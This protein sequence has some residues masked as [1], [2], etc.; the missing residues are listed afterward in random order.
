MTKM[1]PLRWLDAGVRGDLLALAGG[2]ALPLAFAPF[3]LFFL[4]PLTIALL[5]ALWL[6]V[7][8]RQA[9]WR[10]FLFGMGQFGVGVSWVYVAIHDFGGTGA[11]LAV[12]L[13]L[14]F[15]AT[16]ALCVALAGFLA[17]RLRG[18]RTAPPL[19]F[20]LLGAPAAWVLVEWLRSWFLTGFPWLALGYSQIDSPL[21]GWAPLFGVLALSSLAA[22]SG[23]ALALL[24]LERNRAWRLVVPLLLLIWGGACYWTVSSGP[25]PTAHRSRSA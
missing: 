11:P 18:A 21:H 7:T 8:P 16:L 23:G 2:A 22:L 14:L 3:N 1:M 20:L 12:V 5:F 4:A 19:R 6:Y 15:V 10:G 24:V 9:A 13:T 25:H 17:V